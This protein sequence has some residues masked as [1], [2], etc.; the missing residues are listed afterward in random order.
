MNWML[1]LY[2]ARWRKRYGEEFAAVLAEQRASLG[3]VFDVLA[4]AI[5]AHLHPQIYHSQSKQNEGEDTMTNEMLQRCAAGGPR[6]SPRDQKVASMF[7]IGS[8]LVMAVAYI[9]L[10]KIYHAAPAVEALGYSSFPVICLI[11]TQTAY[12]RKRPVMTQI[13]IASAGIVAMYLFMLGTCVIA[14]K[15]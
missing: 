9:V 14:S 10:R 4:G 15:L 6:L 13:L 1:R 2:P 7:M 5:D 3:L 12:L 11:Y 8:A